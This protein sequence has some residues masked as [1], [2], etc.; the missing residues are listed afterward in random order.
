VCGIRPVGENRFVIAPRPGGSLTYAAACY[1]G[2]CGRTE[3]KWEKTDNGTVFTITVPANC[4]AVVCL[5]DG[6]EFVQEAGTKIYQT[7]E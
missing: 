1:T 6:R 7:E 4:Q 3:S 5:P 2:I